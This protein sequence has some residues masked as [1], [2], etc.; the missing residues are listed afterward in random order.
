ML[1]LVSLAAG[2]NF[3]ILKGYTEGEALYLLTT[4][5][6][7]AEQT[8]L[9]NGQSYYVT[10]GS[11]PAGYLA[12]DGGD[13]S[14]TSG[15][16]DASMTMSEDSSM[17]SGSS[18]SETSATTTDSSSTSESSSPTSDES[19]SAQSSQPGAG[20][21][22]SVFSVGIGMTLFTALVFGVMA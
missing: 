9:G 6:P 5:A 1:R 11:A 3:E 8:T 14:Q 13:A 10:S 15:G 21:R 19:A 7:G 4:S 18:P 12:T 22:V 16:G 2:F 17:S 20:S